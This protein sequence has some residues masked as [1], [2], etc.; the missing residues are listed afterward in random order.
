MDIVVNGGSGVCTSE[1]GDERHDDVLASGGTQVLRQPFDVA[2]YMVD[3]DTS[4]VC[5]SGGVCPC[6]RHDLKDSAYVVF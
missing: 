1:A 4:T 6:V 2:I 3:Q 5:L